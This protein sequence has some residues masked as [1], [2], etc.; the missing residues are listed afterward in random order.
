MMLLRRSPWAALMKKN[1]SMSLRI[2][3]PIFTPA[4]ASNRPKSG[5]PMP[6]EPCRNAISMS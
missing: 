4:L 1:V 6:N 5:T 3:N 2:A